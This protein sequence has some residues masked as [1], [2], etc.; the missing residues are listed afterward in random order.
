MRLPISLFN[1]KFLKSDSFD[2][3]HIR[4]ILSIKNLNFRLFK[5]DN[6]SSGFNYILFIES[7]TPNNSTGIYTE[8]NFCWYFKNKKNRDKVA[9][10]LLMF[11]K[12]EYIKHIKN[13]EK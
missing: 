3:N 2:K 8:N 7:L 12:K 5:S 13:S 9:K 1:F 11:I 10:K 6:S 4:T